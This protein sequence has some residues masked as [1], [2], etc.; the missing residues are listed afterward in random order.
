[1]D[2]TLVLENVIPLCSQWEQYSICFC[3]YCFWHHTDR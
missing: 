2:A 3:F 1:M